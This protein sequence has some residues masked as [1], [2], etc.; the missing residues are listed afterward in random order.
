MNIIKLWFTYFGIVYVVDWPKVCRIPFPR[1]RTA[2]HKQTEN[3]QCKQ[4]LKINV[5]LFEAF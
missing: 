5:D 2:L 1:T 3:I 4:F